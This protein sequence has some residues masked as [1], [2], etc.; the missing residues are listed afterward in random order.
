MSRPL[1]GR[2]KGQNRCERIDRN[3][4]A[5]RQRQHF[6]FQFEIIAF[7]RAA[8]NLRALGNDRLDPEIEQLE[9]V[10]NRTHGAPAEARAETD[11][12]FMRASQCL[13]DVLT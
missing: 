3:S 2:E 10:V 6:P 7:A 11:N 13:T 12:D 5:W 9:N 8:I 4:L 1:F